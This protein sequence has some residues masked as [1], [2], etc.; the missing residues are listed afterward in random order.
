MESNSGPADT[1]PDLSV[2][3]G[4]LRLRNPVITASGTFGYGE[5]YEGL[6]DLERLGAIV[7]K[8][9]SLEPRAGNPP[10]RLVETP[11]GPINA[12]GLE[13]V[14]SEKF[15]SAKLPYLRRLDVPVIVNI[16]GN[17]IEEYA[18]LA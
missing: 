11:A 15:I 1:A 3:L 6:A 9:I 13:N 2:Q 17:T 14:G 4:P 7:V 16:F 8:G 12:I 10:P 5:E 18:E